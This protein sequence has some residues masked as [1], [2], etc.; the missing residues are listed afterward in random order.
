MASFKDFKDIYFQ[1]TVKFYK[2]E[3]GWGIIVDKDGSERWFGIQDV[4]GK[5]ILNRHQSVKFRS[6]YNRNGLTAKN[7]TPINPE[8]S[9]LRK[10]NLLLLK[11][12]SRW[13]TEAHR[14]DSKR[15]FYYTEQI[16]DIENGEKHF[17]IGRKGT[18]KS[19]I[20]QYLSEKAKSENGYYVEKLSFSVFPYSEIRAKQ[21]EKVAFPN[22]YVSLWKYV[23]Y[24]SILKMMSRSETIDSQLRELLVKVFPDN[25]IQR[26]SKLFEEM[27]NETISVG[28]KNLVQYKKTTKN[29][30]VANLSWTDKVDIF[31]EIILQNIDGAKYQILF[32][33]LDDSYMDIEKKSEYL[34]M[35]ASLFKAVQSIKA[36]FQI[37]PNNIQ[38]IVFLRDDIYNQIIDS[39]KSKWKDFEASLI[40]TREELK[41]MLAYRITRSVIPR[42]A[43]ILPFKKAW[44]RVCFDDSVPVK[45]G[46]KPFFDYIIEYTFLRPRDLIVFLKDSCQRAKSAGRDQI[47]AQVID[48]YMVEY[49]GDLRNDLEMEILP[50]L[51]RIR[52]IM[53]TI[54]HVRSAVFPYKRLKP[55]LEKL[56]SKEI[57][58][59]P[60]Y[61]DRVM[62]TLFNFNV[63]GNK[64]KN[65]VHVFSY[66]KKYS[67]IN[68][69]ENL[70]IHKGLLKSMAIN[71]Y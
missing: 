24:S 6:D 20:V 14:E 55:K 13:K 48:K 38:P 12:I 2:Q 9:S 64:T 63:I 62:N 8:E 47:N 59:N 28:I 29:Q 65:N 54:S 53:M 50:I 68:L 16:E 26:L 34:Q 5:Q 52:E 49:S 56:L 44:K 3:K 41:N 10:E 69:E 43:E 15:Y 45:K 17:I 37:V 35:L 4:K 40:W 19:A 11:E 67:E 58:E 51:P 33:E 22:Q 25:P 60:I 66:L 61:L 23:I 7:V 30:T 39:D 42:R 18:G 31:E 1:G 27:T 71:D 32:D 21:D 57:E 70:I 36:L 46:N